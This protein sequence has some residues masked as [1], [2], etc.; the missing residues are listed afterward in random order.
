M[1]SAP[2]SRAS[3][4][5][6]GRSVSG[7]PA[8]PSWR[9]RVA[10]RRAP[11]TVADRG[12]ARP[13]RGRRSTSAVARSA[14]AARRRRP[15]TATSG[16]PRS[17]ATIPTPTPSSGAATIAVSTSGWGSATRPA[18]SRIGTR[19]VS[20]RPSPPSASGT[21]SA[22]HAHR[23]EAVPHA[24]VELARRARPTRRGRP[25]ACTPW[26]AGRAPRR[27]TPT[28][29]SV[30]GRT[31]SGEPQE[32]LGGDVALDLVGAGVDRA[33]QR[34]LPALAPR[35]L[36]LGVGAEQVEGDLVQLDVELATT[37]AW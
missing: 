29:S 17:V 28:W 21:S 12:R 26:R 5:A 32:A 4:T 15:R 9:R 8:V 33:R 6:A 36:E 18:S 22:E 24:A 31:S 14:A 34:E 20:S 25:R 27:G 19:K 3:S 30:R 10:A 2:R 7:S 16:P 1:P 11:S 35:A 23:V 37:T 13:R